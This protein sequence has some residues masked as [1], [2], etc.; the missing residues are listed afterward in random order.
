MHIK[1]NKKQLQSYHHQQ[2]NPHQQTTTTRQQLQ[3]VHIEIPSSSYKDDP[4]PICGT[5]Q[6]ESQ[7]LIEYF[8]ELKR[9]DRAF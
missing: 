7:F 6:S 9:R 3:E 8:H 4:R 1:A 5:S 2:Q